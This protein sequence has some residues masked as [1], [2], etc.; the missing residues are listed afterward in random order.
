V[1]ETLANLT[2]TLASLFLGPRFYG[3]GYALSAL[4][5]C[6][7]AYLRLEQTLRDLEFL[8]FA[9]KP[10]APAAELVASAGRAGS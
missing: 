1:S 8:T 10:L 4:L 7:W 9:S 3:Q 6:G 2:L 5:A